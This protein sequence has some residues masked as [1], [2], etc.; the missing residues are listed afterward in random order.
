MK[1]KFGTGYKLTLTVTD[2][3]PADD[4]IKSIYPNAVLNDTV[5]G[6]AVTYEIRDPN[7]SLVDLFREMKDS[8]Q[9]GI[10]EWGINQ[11]S[12]EDVFLNI[13]EQTE[14]EDI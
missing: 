9:Y 6:G 14:Q 5:G 8:D 7:F 13:V 11:S 1:N 2:P 4:F 12:L 3:K 10:L